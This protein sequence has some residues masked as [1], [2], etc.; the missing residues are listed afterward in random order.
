MFASI[1]LGRQ[2][3][4]HNPCMTH[5]MAKLKSIVEGEYEALKHILDTIDTKPLFEK[6][7]DGE[8]EVAGKR[9]NQAVANV[10]TLI[11]NLLVRRKHRLPEG[12]IDYEKKEE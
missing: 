6:Y 4:K 1:V 9:M 2:D 7:A 10:A 11:H 12:H 3:Y 5:Y 8:D